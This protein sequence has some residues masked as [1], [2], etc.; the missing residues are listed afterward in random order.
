V[1]RCLIVMMSENIDL[2]YV[3]QGFKTSRLKF[4]AFL[5][6]YILHCICFEILLQYRN[7]LYITEVI[8]LWLEQQKNWKKS[9]KKFKI[10]CVFIIVRNHYFVILKLFLVIKGFILY[11]IKQTALKSGCN[12]TTYGKFTDTRWIEELQTRKPLSFIWA[13]FILFLF[14]LNI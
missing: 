2:T 1:G 10:F 11:Q 12:F 4:L 5:F 9:N 13:F 8:L 6:N 7:I 14:G 3:T